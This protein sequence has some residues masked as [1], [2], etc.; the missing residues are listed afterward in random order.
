MVKDLSME[1]PYLGADSE[2]FMEARHKANS[3]LPVKNRTTSKCS[4][5]SINVP[6]FITVELQDDF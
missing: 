2:W 6:S 1:Y 3:L 5:L 4:E